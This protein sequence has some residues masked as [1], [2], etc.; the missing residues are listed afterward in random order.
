MK[1]AT[2]ILYHDVIVGGDYDS[3]GF[4]GGDAA[5]YK[6][7]R[8]EFERHLQAIADAIPQPPTTTPECLDHPG[9]GR[10]L[11]LTFD[12]G[13][14]SAQTCI[15]GMLEARGWRGHFLITV[16]RIDEPAFVSRDQIR[17]LHGR[18]HVIGSHSCSHPD[19]MAWCSWEQLLE[20]WTR[21][22]QVLSDIVGQE[23]RT[24][25][26]PGGYYSRDVARA[27][28]TAGLRV[29]FTSEPQKRAWQVDNCLV[30][31]RYSVW[32]G[33]SAATAA[34]FASGRTAV[35]MK[36]YLFWNSKKLAKKLAGPL[37]LKLRSRVLAKR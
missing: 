26:L 15:A 23:V 27:A 36:Q 18:G 10:P 13:G 5:P 24:A 19:P 2:S 3:S 4:P 1:Q 31:G 9:N 37:Y 11:F 16:D 32:K 12:D 29:L 34:G 17:D 25:S 30:M 22:R 7:D 35:Q 14:S 6:L 33:M 21:S 28:S 8:G 20:E